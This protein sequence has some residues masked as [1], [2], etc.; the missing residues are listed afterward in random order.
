MHFKPRLLFGAVL[1]GCLCLIAFAS[2]LQHVRHIEPCPLCILQ[3]MAFI[4][5]GMT[6]LVAVLHNPAGWG[7]RIYAGLMLITAGAGA[8]VSGRQIWL[9]YHPPT[10]IACG[11]DLEFMLDSFPLT[12]AL[13]MLFKGTGDCAKVE[14]T[15]LGLSIPEWAAISFAGIIV[16]SLA[17]VVARRH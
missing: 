11:P 16:V 3:R 8:T 12:Q 1:A 5:T 17:L 15:L 7:S 4:A 10:S 9:Q 14:W 13:P 2:Y 6:A